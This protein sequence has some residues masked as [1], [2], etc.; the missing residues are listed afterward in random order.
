MIDIVVDLVVKHVDLNG[1]QFSESILEHWHSAHDSQQ[2]VREG[3]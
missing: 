1:F 2:N 3:L